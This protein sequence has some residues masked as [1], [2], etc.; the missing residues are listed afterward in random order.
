MSLKDVVETR[1]QRSTN[2]ILIP[3]G[4][5]SKRPL[6]CLSSALRTTAVFQAGE[7]VTGVAAL[8]AAGR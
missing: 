7:S 6:G 3:R 1:A 4:G 2:P 5:R 8:G